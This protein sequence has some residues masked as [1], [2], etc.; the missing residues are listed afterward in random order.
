MLRY[1]RTYVH[2]PLTSNNSHPYLFNSYILEPTLIAPSFGDIF[3]DFYCPSRSIN[4]L[5]LV[6]QT[7]VKECPGQLFTLALCRQQWIQSGQKQ[8]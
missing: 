1:A 6:S 2:S 8:Q 4:F 7:Y 5:L 3:S